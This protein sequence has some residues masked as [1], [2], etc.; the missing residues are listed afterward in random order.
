MRVQER[1]R[2]FMLRNFYVEGAALSDADSLL[3]KGV[4][5]STG[6]M[7]V[8]QFVEGEFGIHV[9]DREIVPENLDSI[10]RIGAYVSR[11]LAA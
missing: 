9:E 5:D 11:K 3:D 1:I 7:E 4:I 6:V 8:I 2:E 10:A